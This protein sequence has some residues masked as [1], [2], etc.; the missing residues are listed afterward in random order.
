MDI[1]YPRAPGLTRDGADGVGRRETRRPF[2]VAV[3]FD[4]RYWPV[5]DTVSMLRPESGPLPETSVRM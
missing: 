5:F 3:S 2:A 4:Y 1:G